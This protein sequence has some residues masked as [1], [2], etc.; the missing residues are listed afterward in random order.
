MNNTYVFPNLVWTFAPSSPE[1]PGV[2]AAAV[3]HGSPYGA[4]SHRSPYYQQDSVPRSHRR[5]AQWSGT[6]DNV[7]ELA[8]PNDVGEQQLIAHERQR[9]AREIHDGV[10]QDL[11]ALSLAMFAERQRLKQEQLTLPECADTLGEMQQLLDTALRELRRVICGLRPTSLEEQG[12]VTALHSL[13]AE[14]GVQHSLYVHLT[15][16]GDATGMPP[17]LE[18]PI[19][20]T[21]QES[22]HNIVK[23]AQATLVQMVLTVT[24]TTI[25][26]SIQDNGCGFTAEALWQKMRKGHLGLRQ[27]QERI[28]EQH[29]V[30]SINSKVGGGTQLMVTF[31]DW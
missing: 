14:F 30:L 16:Q 29:G 20:R 25:T 23:H 8:K 3:E 27:M 7:E 15:I 9:L 26:F 12:L 6:F 1:P 11:A 28:V 31:T 2:T 24:P 5:G 22:L 10:A 4:P 19:F 18:L 17:A 21:A 13:A